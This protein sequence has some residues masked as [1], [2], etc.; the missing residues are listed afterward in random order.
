VQLG[1]TVERFNGFARAGWDQDYQRGIPK[2]DSQV[3]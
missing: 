3:R 1:E 2:A